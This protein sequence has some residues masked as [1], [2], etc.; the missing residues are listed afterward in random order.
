[1]RSFVFHLSPLV[2]EL[3]LVLGSR[4]DGFANL[5]L[6]SL[7]GFSAQIPLVSIFGLSLRLIHGRRRG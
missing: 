2:E 6:R 7:A 5:L 4:L 1:M 3:I